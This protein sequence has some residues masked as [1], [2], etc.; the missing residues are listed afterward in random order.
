MPQNP[1]RQVHA[2]LG[3]FWEL[4]QI[5]YSVGGVVNIAIRNMPSVYL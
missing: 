5:D 3:V 2:L 4:I 1:T